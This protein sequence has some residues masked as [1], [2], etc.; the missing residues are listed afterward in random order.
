MH[1]L[2]DLSMAAAMRNIAPPYRL[3]LQVSAVAVAYFM[4]GKLA[5]FFAIA[6]SY[7]SPI[8]P[9][10]GI[11][12][13]A[14]LIFGKRLWLGVFIGAFLVNLSLASSFTSVWPR[15]A[16]ALAVAG[17][18]ALQAVSG[19]YLI[20]RFTRFPNQLI[21]AT[22]VLIFFLLAALISPVV[23]SSIGV[24]ILLTSGLVSPASLLHNWGSWYLGDS[25]GILMLTPI[26]FVWTLGI[27][28][29]G[30]TRRLNI[31]MPML[32]AF[33]LTIATIIYT[34]EK[35]QPE[36][37]QQ[38]SQLELSRAG[39]AFDRGEQAVLNPAHT[40]GAQRGWFELWP[41]ATPAKQAS[42]NSH[43][44]NGQW[45]TLLAGL[46]LTA[47][48]G[49]YF[50][51]LSGRGSQLAQL[52]EEHA[53]LI[54]DLKAN[55][56][57]LEDTVVARTQ[58]LKSALQSLSLSEERYE[59]AMDAVNDGLFDWDIN[60]NE[61]YVNDNYLSMLGY[62]PDE[63]DYDANSCWIDLLHPS[64][65]ATVLAGMQQSF[66]HEAMGEFEFRMRCRDGSYK[67]IMSRRKV[68]ERNQQGAAARVVGTHTDITLRKQIELQLLHNEADLQTIFAQSPDGIV[69]FDHR[70]LLSDVNQLFCQM[71][72]LDKQQLIG[73]NEAEF[74]DM[75]RSLG[76]EAA[77]E[78]S[79][80]RRQA[81]NIFAVDPT[82]IAHSGKRIERSS[83][84]VLRPSFRILQHTVTAL[85]QQRISSLVHFRDITGEAM[86]DRMKS[87]F[88]M[89]AAHELRTPMTIIRGYVELLKQ[90]SYDATSQSEMLDSIDAQSQSIVGLLDELLDLSRIESR[91]GK[92]FNLV[93]APLAT[94]IESL[95][96]SLIVCGDSRQVQI[97]P[98][99][100]LPLLLIDQEKISQAL[101][102]CLSNAF[103]YSKAPTEVSL[104]VTVVSRH[105]HDE[106]AIR[107]SD[108][109]IGMTPEQ[110]SHIF[111]KFYRADV[112]G[113]VAG[114][115]LGL[116]LVKEI[117]E[118]HGGR[119]EVIS[120]MQAQD[121]AHGTV[122]TLWLP[123][124]NAKLSVL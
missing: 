82:H 5:T 21:S 100:A 64:E 17:A 11:A 74:N 9:A 85:N 68:V 18:V 113:K 24:L 29:H 1:S 102:N 51:L 4:A 78:P 99:P 32:L 111:E 36:F 120:Q 70:H 69:I 49:I 96:D 23:G 121:D 123:M 45:L 55:R 97:K 72:G 118:H 27:S 61:V 84:E 110:L 67:W 95:A 87:E 56:D 40:A 58:E 2:N 119:V 8:W 91:A 103:K 52:A 105:D 81:L 12:L 34:T 41:L 112:S 25:L 90:R 124:V 57:N 19:A 92:A 79:N 10:A 63:M 88:L 114:T 93:L 47:L 116:T 59:L 15:L 71:T 43:R 50:L 60:S 22:E 7:V 115:G 104:E 20:Q 37:A 48:T 76:G 75:M 30:K 77:M 109:G 46:V 44:S 66:K 94:I 53:Q 122:V 31:S 80:L 26:I 54:A 108:Q 28:R 14:V 98:I 39:H 101:K 89:T 65:K 3:M 106:V 33:L 83:I 107:I 73:A 38:T 35:P 62:A 42:V 117:M 16:I 13:A 6:P 86:V